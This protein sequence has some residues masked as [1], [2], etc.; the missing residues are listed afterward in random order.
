MTMIKHVESVQ[1][2]L[3]ILMENLRLCRGDNLGSREVIPGL[4]IRL[5]QDQECYD[6]LKWWATTGQKDDYDWGDDTLPYL[7]IEN[8]NPLEPVNVSVTLV[9]VKVL[10]VLLTSMRYPNGSAAHLLGLG[11]KPS[12]IAKNPNIA[13]CDDKQLKP[14]AQ[15][16]LCEH[17]QA[18]HMMYS[19]GSV[20]HMQATLNLTYEAWHEALGAVG[21]IEMAI[22][23]DL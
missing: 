4:M 8:A 13:N 9:K 19:I 10:Q 17:L 14:K 15:I 16:A 12:T 2:Q 22:E 23:G 3:D 6:F 1:A 7:D 20:Q 11:L 18:K 5:H 21:V